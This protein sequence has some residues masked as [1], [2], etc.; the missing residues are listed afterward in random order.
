MGP[1]ERRL[2]KGRWGLDEKELRCWA[3]NLDTIL[4]QTVGSYGGF[5]TVTLGRLIWNG[6][7]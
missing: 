3:G 5:G 1:Q 7:C 6:S 4:G 2:G